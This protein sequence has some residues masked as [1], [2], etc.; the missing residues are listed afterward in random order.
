M[1][2][3]T[4]VL[5]VAR[6]RRVVRYRLDSHAQSAAV[7]RKLLCMCFEEVAR[8]S[9]FLEFALQTCFNQRVEH[10]GEAKRQSFILERRD[11]GAAV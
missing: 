4:K 10:R 2:Q 8:W 9:G 3:E 6:R 1:V 11:L 7:M 5:D